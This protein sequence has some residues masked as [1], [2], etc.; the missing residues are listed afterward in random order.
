M[1]VLEW[2]SLDGSVFLCGQCVGVLVLYDCVL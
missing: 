2:R 1:I